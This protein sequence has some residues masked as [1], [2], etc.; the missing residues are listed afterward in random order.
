MKAKLASILTKCSQNKFKESR[1]YVC[2]ISALAMPESCT[3]ILNDGVVA[4]N[5]ILTSV[6][7]NFYVLY[8]PW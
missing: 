5:G 3:N 6:A 8:S 4:Q 7:M 2:H 1:P